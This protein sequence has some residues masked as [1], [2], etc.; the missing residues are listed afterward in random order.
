MFRWFLLCLVVCVWPAATVRAHEIPARDE[1]HQ[2]LLKAVAFF[3]KQV[4]S[5]GGYVWQYSGDLQLREGEG[6]TTPTV[7]WVQPPGTP[8]VGE[9]FLDA[10]EATGDRTA[11]AAAL[12]AA[13]ALILGQLHSGG[14]NYFIEFAP[15]KRQAFSYR[16]NLDGQPR[17]DPVT[18]KDRQTANG[19]AVWKRR[20]YRGNVTTLDDDTTQAALRFLMRLD[21]TLQFK[22]DS[23][24]NAA[25]YALT[26][27]LHM[28]YPNGGWSANFDRWQ[29]KSP[30]PQDYPVKKASYPENWSR[31]WPKDFT[32]CYV[33]NDD[34]MADM[35]QTLLL[36]W[37]VYQEK[38]YLLAAEKAGDFL[39]LAQMPQPQPAWAQQYDRDMQP[40]WSRAFEP[41]A[42]SGLESQG[43][44]KALL[45]L[46]RRT[47]HKKY[48]EPIPAAL[49]YLRKA[50]L[51][52]GR[53]ARFYELQTNRPLYFSRGTDRRYQMTYDSTHA[54]THYGFAFRSRLDS[55]EK[56]Y[57]RLQKPKPQPQAARREKISPALVQQTRQVLAGLD[58]RGAW[59]EQRPLRF[60]KSQPQSGI[61]DCATFARNVGI[62]CR[63]LQ[64]QDE[65]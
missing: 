61:I 24:H 1:V 21:K 30:N 40:V 10:Y 18:E 19:W 63:F 60:H 26:A 46:Q 59:A 41:P 56:E 29:E 54:V 49:A 58:R 13:K 38:R 57:Q 11:L 47:G 17:P 39:L 7:I 14:W 2:A 28:Q 65:R 53:L 3:H 62:L 23:I 52:D 20:R 55:I 45:L 6:R 50:Q 5:H 34:L 4:A 16:L 31:T 37:D 48:L 22:N 64:A 44:M 33:T 15:Q 12:D 25:E 36:A 9:A 43:I 8:S 32:G 35:I 42:I 27:L 51:P